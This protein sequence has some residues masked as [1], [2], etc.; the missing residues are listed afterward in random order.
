LVLVMTD[1][2]DSPTTF[3]LTSGNVYMTEGVGSPIQLNTNTVTVDKLLFHQISSPKTPDQIMFDAAFLNAQ[4][5]IAQM[6]KTFTSHTT[7]SLRQ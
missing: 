2:S 7:L 3:T 1:T 6:N 4:Q 5:D